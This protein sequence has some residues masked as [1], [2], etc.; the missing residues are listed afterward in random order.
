MSMYVDTNNR[1]Y[2]LFDQHLA[3][4]CPTCQVL[5]HISPVSVPQYNQLV[6]F[7]PKSVG[8]VYRCDACNSPIFLKFTVKS[9]GSN[10]V[11]LSPT[12]TEIE[13]AMEKFDFTYLPEDCEILFKEALRCYSNSS[14][15]A[16][17]S[18]CR[19][20]AQSAFHD[21]GENGRLRIFDQFAE[22]QDMA[23][24]DDGTFAALK[25]VIFDD[26]SDMPPNMPILTASEAGILLESMKD[27]LYQSYVRKGKLQQAMMMRKYFVDEEGA[28]GAPKVTA[29]TPEIRDNT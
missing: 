6:R 23:E 16:F 7:K 1:L 10:R 27:M 20:T 17:A 28:G 3:L 5:S 25:K 29:I 22:V 9:Y 12:Y 15:N 21:L 2:H 4:K 26:D 18:M 19:R 24:I 13:R 11:E 8:L 14:F